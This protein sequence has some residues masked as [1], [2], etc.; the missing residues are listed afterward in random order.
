MTSI[1]IPFRAFPIC[2]TLNRLFSTAYS[3]YAGPVPILDK[4]SM[5]QNWHKNGTKNPAPKHRLFAR[6]VALELPSSLAVCPQ[7]TPFASC[8][9]RKFQILIFRSLR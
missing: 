8:P 1:F 7:R 9:T 6:I 4:N 3:S 2:A 5:A